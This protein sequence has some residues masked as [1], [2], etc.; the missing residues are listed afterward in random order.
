MEGMLFYDLIIRAHIRNHK[1]SLKRYLYS[2]HP[3]SGSRPGQDTAI[4]NNKVKAIVAFE[5]GSSF[6]FPKE[7]PAPMP[8]AFDT[9]K[10]ES[11]PMEQFMAPTKIP[12]LIIYGDNIPYKSVAIPAQDSWQWLVNGVTW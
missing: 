11:V 1:S 12:I 9:L 3:L 5:P 6:V 7:F 10:G 8:G 2:L 4:K